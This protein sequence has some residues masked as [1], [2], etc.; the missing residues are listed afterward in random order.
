MA[1]L[2]SRDAITS[3]NYSPVVNIVTWILLV[4]MVLAVCAK[5]A[6]KIIGRRSFNIDDSMLVAAMVLSAAQSATLSVQTY[7]GVGRPFESLTISQIRTYEKAGYSADLLYIIAL[8]VS[9]VSVLVLLWQLTPV[10]SHRRLTLGVGLFLAAWTIASFFAS[11]FQCP[12]PETWMILDQDC[13][14]R[15]S[16]WTAYGV[17]NILTE[18]ILIFLPTYTI[19]NLHMPGQRKAAAIACFA[20]RVLVIGSIIAQLTILNKKRDTNDAT[21]DTWSY[22]LSAQFVQN[23]SVITACVPYIKNVLVGVESG[24]FQTGRFRL[25]TFRKNSQRNQEYDLSGARSGKETVAESSAV[26]SR[27]M[28]EEI[29]HHNVANE[30]P[31]KNP[32]SA[33]NTATA[34]SVTPTEEWDGGSQS[35]RAKIIRETREW[36]VDYEA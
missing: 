6:M 29:S 7:N 5:V 4:S 35:S 17:I 30:T 14:D 26:P 8:A 28:P 19:W 27:Q 20:I 34:E 21:L 13:F 16:F 32:F 10:T 11:C 3:D 15:V 1:G 2:L 33:E 22:Q 25:A 31:Q 9:K 24:M 18:A 36:Y 12:I 23:L